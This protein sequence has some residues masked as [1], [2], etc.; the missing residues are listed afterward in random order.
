MKNMNRSS[1]R[2]HVRCSRQERIGTG[3]ERLQSRTP[4]HLRMVGDGGQDHTQDVAF[5]VTCSFE[6]L[7]SN[8]LEL[9]AGEGTQLQKRQL[10]CHVAS[11]MLFRRR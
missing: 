4:G 9:C 6:H 1:K 8:S 2:Q 11:V 10:R 5:Y 7:Q 3:Y